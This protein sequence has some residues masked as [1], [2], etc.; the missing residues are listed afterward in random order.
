MEIRKPP[1][2]RQLFNSE[3]RAK[4]AKSAKG[5]N[6]VS[7]FASFASFARNPFWLT[8]PRLRVSSIFETRT[9]MTM[10]LNQKLSGSFKI[11]AQS[12]CPMATPAAI[13][14]IAAQNV[15]VMGSPSVKYAHVVVVT[16]MKLLN[17]ITW[18]VRQ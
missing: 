18:L 6:G 12:A 10:I 8:T 17:S 9:R 13:K 2:I 16:G 7:V 5:G 15:D 4:N 1:S 11:F 3:C 14:I